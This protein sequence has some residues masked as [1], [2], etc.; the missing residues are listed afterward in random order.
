MI[1]PAAV[2]EKRIPMIKR[3]ILPVT[4]LR[5]AGTI[6]NITKGASTPIL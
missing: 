5:T 2:A 1:S 6:P 4:K 3:K